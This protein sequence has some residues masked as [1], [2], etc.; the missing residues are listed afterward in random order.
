MRG[1][2]LRLCIVHALIRYKVTIK[3]VNWI[4]YRKKQQVKRTKIVRTK[5]DISSAADAGPTYKIPCNAKQSE[6][7]HS[8]EKKA[9]QIA[10]DCTSTQKE[11]ELIT[12]C[13]MSDS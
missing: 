3:C 9:K 10:E 11:D 5:R 4:P 8:L 2:T 13:I 7:N 12:P 1:I 6:A